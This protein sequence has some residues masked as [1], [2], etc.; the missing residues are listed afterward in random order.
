MAPV[1]LYSSYTHMY[2]RSLKFND[3]QDR[4]ERVSGMRLGVAARIGC[5]GSCGD[6]QGAGWA[7][8]TGTTGASAHSCTSPVQ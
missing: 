6:S 5:P 1:I 7:P 3:Y 4:E 2:V 8:C